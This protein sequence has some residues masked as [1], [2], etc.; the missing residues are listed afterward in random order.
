[1]VESGD[2]SLRPVCIVCSGI[3]VIPLY[4]ARKESIKHGHFA[5]IHSMFLRSQFSQFAE[6]R[7]SPD[8]ADD[9]F[10]K[11]SLRGGAEKTCL[12]TGNYA[13]ILAE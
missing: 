1:M 10:E 9:F 5:T 3:G 12:I 8:S 7:S 4:Y 6:I 13:G 2:N 11:E